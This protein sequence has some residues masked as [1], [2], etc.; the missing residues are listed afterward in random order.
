MFF[1]RDQG[2]GRVLQDDTD[3]F[4]SISFFYPAIRKHWLGREE[5]QLAKVIHLEELGVSCLQVAIGCFEKSNGIGILTLK[6]G[7]SVETDE[8]RV[9]LAIAGDQVCVQVSFNL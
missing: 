4:C 7:F 5:C 9:Y 1:I 6:K 8:A 3:I 2:R